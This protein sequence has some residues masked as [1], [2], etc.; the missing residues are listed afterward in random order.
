MRLYH[1]APAKWGLENL[2]KK[3]LKIALLDECND[4]F[5]LWGCWQGN[6]SVRAKIETWKRQ[7]ATKHGLLCFT[8]TW[9]NPLMWSHYADRHEGLCLGFDIPDEFV[10]KVRY[11]K[12]RP[13]LSKRITRDEIEDLLFLKYSGWEYEEEWR[14]WAGLDEKVEGRYFCDFGSA[15]VLREVYVGV[16]SKLTRAE[17]MNAVGETEQKVFIKKTRLGFKTFAVVENRLYRNK[18][19][20]D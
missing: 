15:F 12:S 13:K 18:D 3:R 19:W 6:P 20:A 8:A 14:V 4:P 5:E 11:T 9:R 17:I 1:Y 2:K 16:S 7:M 10:K